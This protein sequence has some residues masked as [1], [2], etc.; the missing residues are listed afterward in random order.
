[1]NIVIYDVVPTGKLVPPPIEKQIAV[2]KAL[3][4]YMLTGGKLPVLIASAKLLDS[5]DEELPDNVMTVGARVL[6]T[7]TIPE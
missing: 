6:V 2:L 7:L 4:E 1:M 3:T 5:E